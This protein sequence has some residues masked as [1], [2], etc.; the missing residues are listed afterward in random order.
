M[1]GAKA[2]Y[3]NFP[4]WEILPILGI[5]EFAMRLI[6]IK[7][8]DDGIVAYPQAKK[9]LDVWRDLVEEAD[10]KTPHE[11]RAQFGNA[12]ILPE[13]QVVFNI[14]GNHFR[15]LAKVDYQTKVVLVK[16]FGT[17]AE[18]DSWNL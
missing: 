7:V 16:K 5:I 17:H 10:W 13:K 9:Q 2:L 3:Y 8:L 12:D 15:L 6:G 18:Y 11:L 1:T 4:K 14:K